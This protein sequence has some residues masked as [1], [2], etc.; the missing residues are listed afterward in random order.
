MPITRQRLPWRR[1]PAASPPGL[2]RVAVYQ[3]HRPDAAGP[4]SLDAQHDRIRAFLDAHLGR[5]LIPDQPATGPH[6]H[7]VHT[8]PRRHV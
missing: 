7:D 5:D 2:L 6:R 1:R 4:G 3:R 8:P